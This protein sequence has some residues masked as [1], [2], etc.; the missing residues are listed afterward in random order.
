MFDMHFDLTNMY[1]F[2]VNVIK[3]LANRTG[4]V[5]KFTKPMVVNRK[6]TMKDFYLET[7]SMLHLMKGEP[8][9]ERFSSIIYAIK[10]NRLSM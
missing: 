1:A 10:D 9:P 5:A 7:S 4:S 2:K 8:L 3:I 6:A